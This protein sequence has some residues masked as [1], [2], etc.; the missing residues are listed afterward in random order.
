MACLACIVNPGARTGEGIKI[1]VTISV[2]WQEE[3]GAQKAYPVCRWSQPSVEAVLA[4][5]KE[6]RVQLS[7]ITDILVSTF[8]EA[9][10]LSTRRPQDCDEAQYSLPL[11]VAIA[12][13][14]GTI[15]PEHIL[16]QK[17]DTPE[18]WRVVDMVRFAECDTYN[19][20]FPDERFADV[21][22]VLSDDRV[23]RSQ[24]SV[25]RGNHDAP[26]TDHEIL[27]KFAHYT[28]PVMAQDKCDAIAR[29]LTEPHHSLSPAELIALLHP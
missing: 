14:H 2:I 26:L 17:F 7:N 1:S 23:L 9:T 24:P 13:T 28:S 27:A 20:A 22:L 6:H 10:H 19:D 11:A 5:L 16:P 3:G 18:I 25:A 15:L 8:H 12:L 21:T 29:I 4:L